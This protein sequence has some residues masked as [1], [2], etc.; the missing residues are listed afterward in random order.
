MQLGFVFVS[1]FFVFSNFFVSMIYFTKFCWNFDKHP[2]GMGFFFSFFFFLF[3]VLYQFCV[4]LF[5]LLDSWITVIKIRNVALYSIKLGEEAL[6]VWDKDKK[7]VNLGK[8]QQRAIYLLLYVHI[9]FR[10]VNILDVLVPQSCFSLNVLF[11]SSCNA[12]SKQG[13]GIH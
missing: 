10:L 1:C 5:Y 8:N 11:S 12:V 7:E 2:F 9:Y 4:F 6:S 3:Y 13:V